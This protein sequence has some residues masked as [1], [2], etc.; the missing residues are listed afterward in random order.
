MKEWIKDDS[1]LAYYKEIEKETGIAPSVLKRYQD[2]P[3]IQNKDLYI[4]EAVSFLFSERDSLKVIP[5]S[6][7]LQYA[8]VFPIHD[9]EKFVRIIRKVDLI[10]LNELG[11]KEAE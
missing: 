10:V 5:L 3:K 7:I 8:E 6:N 2:K 1:D 11:N 4:Y 9:L